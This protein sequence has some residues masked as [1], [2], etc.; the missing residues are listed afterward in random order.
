VRVLSLDIDVFVEPVAHMQS[1]YGHRRLNKR[2]C[3]LDPENRRAPTSERRART[4]RFAGR[5]H[6][7]IAPAARAL[8]AREARRQHTLVPRVREQLNAVR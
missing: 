8:V 6:Q 7:V 4:A 2:G 3:S 1:L 5:R